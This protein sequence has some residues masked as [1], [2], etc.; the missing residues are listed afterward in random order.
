MPA[1]RITRTGPDTFVNGNRPS[2][3]ADRLRAY[4]PLKGMEPRKVR[5][6]FTLPVRI[7]MVGLTLI[8]IAFQMGWLS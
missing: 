7:V 4:G 2:T 5:D 8:V 1:E 6:W 3:D